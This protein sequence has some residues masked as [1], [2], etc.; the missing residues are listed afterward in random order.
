MLPTCITEA[1]R[2]KGLIHEHREKAESLGTL[3]RTE[4]DPIKRKRLT[5]RANAQYRRCGEYV[6]QLH[7]LQQI[8]Q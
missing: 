8:K 3:A 6:R 7:K 4:K 1:Q 5:A 2:L